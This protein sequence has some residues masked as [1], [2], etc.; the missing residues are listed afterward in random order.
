MALDARKRRLNERKF[1]QWSA[2]PNGGRRYGYDVPGRLGWTARYVK[3]V[4]AA[5]ETVR[6]RQEIF[7]E[8]GAA[9]RGPREVPPG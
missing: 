2:L 3:E 1:G 8:E 5:E 9:Y 6:F 7:D 4:D